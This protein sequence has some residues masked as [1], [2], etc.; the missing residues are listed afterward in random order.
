MSEPK[1]KSLTKRAVALNAWLSLLGRVPIIGQL[2]KENWGKAIGGL[3]GLVS[4]GW[5][6]VKGWLETLGNWTPLELT[7]VI[8]GGLVALVSLILLFSSIWPTKKARQALGTV[9]DPRADEKMELLN[10]LVGHRHLLTDLRRGDPARGDPAKN[11]MVIPVLNRIPVVFGPTSAPGRIAARWLNTRGHDT[12]FFTLLLD[13][14]ARNTGT[15]IDID[16]PNEAF[17]SRPDAQPDEDPNVVRLRA[18]VGR[19]GGIK[20]FAE[21]KSSQAVTDIAGLTYDLEEMG[22][23][24]PRLPENV[25]ELEPWCYFLSYLERVAAAGDIGTARTLVY[26]CARRHPDLKLDSEREPM[27]D[28]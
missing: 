26:E 15:E 6:A 16:T 28:G 20:A 17:I 23:H 9:A 10:A 11:E 7:V 22:V 5:T 8:G 19:F 1:E 13:A 27:R 12:V 24:Y 3:A 4:A 18:L 14:M 25:N 21:M 2:L